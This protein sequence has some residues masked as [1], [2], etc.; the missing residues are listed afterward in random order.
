M[1]KKR[2]FLRLW[3]VI[4]FFKIYISSIYGNLSEHHCLFIRSKA[5]IIATSIP[6]YFKIVGFSFIFCEDDLDRPGWLLDKADFHLHVQTWHEETRK[7]LRPFQFTVNL[8]F[9]V[10]KRS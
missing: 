6:F 2:E 9:N 8:Y 5:V 4:F 1:G 10:M 3:F 7:K